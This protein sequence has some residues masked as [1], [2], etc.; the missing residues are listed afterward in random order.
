VI[1]IFFR[2]NNNISN[3]KYVLGF[4][5]FVILEENVLF[6]SLFLAP[7][8]CYITLEKRFKK[9]KIKLLLDNCLLQYRVSIVHGKQKITWLFV[10]E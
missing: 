7:S 6:F 9:T 1:L 8:V 3:K 5:F 2:Q 4:P 10:H